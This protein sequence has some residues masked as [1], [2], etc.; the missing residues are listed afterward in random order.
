MPRWSVRCAP[1]RVPAERK[2]RQDVSVRR[3]CNW[4]Y[5]PVRVNFGDMPAPLL[6]LTMVLAQAPG[7]ARPPAPAQATE[8]LHYVCTRAVNP[9]SIDG[10]LDDAAW[11]AAAWSE[12]FVDIEGSAQPRPPLR[13]RM[14]L[15]WDDRYLY[16]AGELEEPDVWGTLTQR[17]AV[18]FQDNDFEL[19]IDP[20]A[21]THD[22]YELEINALGTVWD[23]FLVKPYR[24]GGP[25]LHGWDIAGL[26][27]AVRVQGTLNRPGDR[28]RGWTVELALPWSALSEAAPE[29]RA[30]RAGEYWRINFSRVEWDVDVRASGYAKRT[31]ARTGKALPEHNW[32]WSPQGVIDMHRPELWGIVQ[33]SAATAGSPAV[34][35]TPPPDEA[36]RRALRR[37]YLAEYAWFR[38]HDGY[39]TDLAALGL[40]GGDWKAPRAFEI[41]AG[42]DFFVARAAG[43]AAGSTWHIRDDGRIWRT[44]RAR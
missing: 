26:R 17:D 12:S 43:L 39:T 10:S 24:D 8:P 2:E 3:H 36:V 29:R 40:D 31:D 34:A 5:L 6:L 11:Q 25:P 44:T 28:D 37:V 1:L 35:W 18:I 38:E 22:Y 20:D 33:F 14:K 21:D 27:S 32:V 23:L 13:T 4:R 19:F 7:T 15:L 41:Q 16:V 42:S 9:P 30:P